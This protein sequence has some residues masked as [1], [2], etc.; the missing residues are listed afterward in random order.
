M[1]TEQRIQEQE[2]KDFRVVESIM[3][4]IFTGNNITIKQEEYGSHTDMRMTATTALGDVKYNIEIKSKTGDVE[5]YG[6]VPLRLEKYIY[7][8][9]STHSDE[10]L[11]YIVLSN[12]YYHVFNLTNLNL[13]NVKLRNWRIKDTEYN[14][15]SGMR[16][17]PCMFIPL[18][19]RNSTGII[20]SNFVEEDADNQ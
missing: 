16:Q 3:H 8:T 13:N 2:N 10:R 1:T 20:P 7:M 5:E 15:N 14:S 11:I 18:S 17:Q 4:R 12:G 6:E 19:L 9:G